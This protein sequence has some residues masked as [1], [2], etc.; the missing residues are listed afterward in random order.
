MRRLVLTCF[1]VSAMAGKMSAAVACDTLP[2]VA[3]LLGSNAG[4]GCFNQD[5]LFTNWVTTLPDTTTDVITTTPL[6]GQDFHHVQF[7]NILPGVYTLSY[8]IAV[9]PP[10]LGL[11][12]SVQVAVDINPGTASVAKTVTD[13]DF[14]GVVPTSTGPLTSLPLNPG[15]TSLDVSETITVN[16]GS[17]VNSS[18]DTYVESFPST[19]VP[20]PNAAGLMLGG[21][22]LIGLGCLKRKKRAM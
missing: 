20:E 6:S 9:M 19:G 4:G 21:V 1:F 10:S 17:Q 15:H 18:T 7:L 13:G 14:T 8:T 16:A 22:V 3:L 2:T 12:T 11:I 5:K